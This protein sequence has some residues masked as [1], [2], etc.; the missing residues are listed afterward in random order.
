LIL[1]IRKKLFLTLLAA[2]ALL[3]AVMSLLIQWSFERGFLGYLHNI[4]EQR[5]V[6][7]AANLEEAYSSS[8]DWRF[9]QENEWAWKRLVR[10]AISGQ[11][12]DGGDEDRGRGG[13]ANRSREFRPNRTSADSRH[14][15][16]ENRLLLLDAEHRPIVG[17]PQASKEVE[18]QPLEAAG[19]V[20]GYLGLN[21]QGRLTGFLQQRFAEQQQKTFVLISLG[22]LA[23]A[24]L[25]SLPLAQTMVRRIRALADGTH[26][27][28]GGEF[29]ARVAVSGRDELSQ[30]GRDFNQLARTLEENESARRQWIADISHE[31]RTPLAVLR[32]EIEALQDGVRPTG[33]EALAS[34]HGEVLQLARL[35]DDL[36]QL[37]LSDLGALSYRRIDLDPVPVVVQALERLEPEFAR[38][39][40]A[41]E[42]DLPRPGQCR[43]F[44]DP[45]RLHQLFEALLDNSLKYTDPGG[46]MRVSL[47]PEGKHLEWVFE[48]SPPGVSEEDLARLFER[49]YRVEGSRSRATGGA[50]LGLAICRAIAEAH[51]GTLE[52]GRSDLGGLKLTLR[53]PRG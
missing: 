23:I 52:A 4:E 30:L 48:D 28:A 43:L 34:L 53:L 29:G 1:S 20:I 27:L 16:F 21:R 36:Y 33:P 18:L 32:G 13:D 51:D 24:A 8:G 38:R 42:K 45:E 19:K 15:R 25:L 26:R 46:R 12:P 31:L 40:I 9:L 7:L 39:R 5:L 49:L 14:Q 44:A 22:M 3:V 50:G 17:G 2:T 37:S 41:L 11:E 10:Q 35:V 47:R 6:R